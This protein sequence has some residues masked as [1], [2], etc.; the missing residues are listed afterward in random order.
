MLHCS[1][2]ATDSHLC[3]MHL[4]NNIKFLENFSLLILLIFYKVNKVHAL[5][6]Y[7]WN[8]TMKQVINLFM[9]DT[10]ELSFFDLILKQKQNTNHNKNNNKNTTGKIFLICY[11]GFFFFFFVHLFQFGLLWFHFQA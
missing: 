7:L 10:I 3:Y 5:S 4:N 1:Y 6:Y 8:K 11:L 2:F 9:N